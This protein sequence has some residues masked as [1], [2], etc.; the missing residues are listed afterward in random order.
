MKRYLL[1][2]G[3][4]VVLACCL[5]FVVAPALEAD[6]AAVPPQATKQPA[7]AENADTGADKSESA[8]L[9]TPGTYE[10]EGQGFGGKITVRVTVLESGIQSVE[11]VSNSET[12]GIG[13]PALEKLPDAIVAA[14]GIEVDAVAGASFSSAGLLEAVADALSKA[15]I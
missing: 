13:T 8:A 15:G 6:T 10:G 1:H 5:L 7:V 4:V 2:G 12:A 3:L 14:Q 11:V 9:Y